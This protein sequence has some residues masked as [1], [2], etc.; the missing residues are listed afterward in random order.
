MSLRNLKRRLTRWLDEATD[1][2][3]RREGLL[4]QRPA[5]VG[6]WREEDEADR[7]RPT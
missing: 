2:R 6:R 1:E 3:L 7:G 4:P 5:A